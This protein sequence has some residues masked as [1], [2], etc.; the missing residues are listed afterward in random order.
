MVLELVDF[1]D[2][3]KVICLPDDNNFLDSQFNGTLHSLISIN[4]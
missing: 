4:N 2:E 1:T 3:L